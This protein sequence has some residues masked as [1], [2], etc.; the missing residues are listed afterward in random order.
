MVTPDARSRLIAMIR[1]ALEA[2]DCSCSAQII[3]D[4]K[5]GSACAMWWFGT[6]AHQRV[7][8][9]LGGLSNALAG[10]KLDGTMPHGV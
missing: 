9:L 10:S 2:H 8:K 4:A 7:V 1:R 3:T 5:A 6:D